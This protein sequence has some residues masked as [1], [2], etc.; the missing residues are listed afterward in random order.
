MRSLYDVVEGAT[1][2]PSAV[3]VHEYVAYYFDA[4]D[5]LRDAG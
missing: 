1:G 4:L 5:T 2:G 3:R